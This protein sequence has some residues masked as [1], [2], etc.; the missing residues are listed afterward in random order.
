M[1]Q[2]IL[3]L[4][5]F[6]FCSILFA[7]SELELKEISSK[8]DQNKNAQLEK[9]LTLDFETNQEQ[10]DLYLKNNPFLAKSLNLEESSRW[11]ERINENGHPVFIITTNTQGAE[12]IGANQLYS[13]GSLGLDIDG[14]G[15][16]AGI[17][18]GGYVLQNHQE[19]NRRVRYGEADKSVSGHGTHVG[20]TMI[21][22]GDGRADARGMAPGGRLKSFRFD[23]DVNEMLEQAQDGLL[24]SNH[25]YGREVTVDTE[26]EVFGQYD[27]SARDFD[28]ITDANPYY[29]PV[30]SAGNDRGKDYNSGK[31]EY[32][33]LTDRTTSKNA[34]TVGA[35]TG[36]TDNDDPSNITMSN[37][38][39]WGP[40]DDG[41]IKPDLV[42]KGVS[43]LSTSDQSNTSYSVLQGTSMSS[44][45]VA[46]GLMLLHQLYNE[47]FESF[48][49]SA[50][51]K[52]LVLFTAKE[53]GNTPGPDYRFGWGLLDVEAAAE[54]L[55]NV[56]NLN[57]GVIEEKELADQESLTETF[58]A[59]DT[60]R[61]SFALSWTDLPG[62]VKSEYTI[63]DTTPVLINDLDL[64][65]VDDEGNEFFPYKL[66]VERFR[67][68][69]TTGVNNVDNIEI[70]HI[71]APAGNY[72]VEI[73]H[74]GVLDNPQNYSLLVNGATKA[75]ASTSSE[76]IAGLSIFPNP[77]NDFVN[78]T[79]NATSVSNNVTIQLY[80]TLGQMVKNESFNNNGRFNQRVNISDL[81][82]GV[83]F[84]AVSDGNLKSTRKLIVK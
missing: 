14:S 27:F 41:R 71:N 51:I 34:L 77:A 25:S 6:L 36:S 2:K 76:E 32:D 53:A 8:S 68:R 63:D 16:T 55:L 24:I 12:M 3:T 54:M 65:V 5:V 73:T 22:S 33:L 42:A 60:E 83:Y 26:L 46:G 48:M 70:I 37:F 50:T 82:S 69:A 81:R 56:S 58:T 61:I 35:V 75:T 23:N 1:F 59:V 10:V 29:L 78:I 44:P 4:T 17:W 31:A 64:K 39:S 72:R 19:F 47:L 28:A 40:T 15:I 52:G 7:Q 66:D 79:F 45:M 30:V 18:D 21:A 9:R 43:V 49:R 11:L 62:E 13:G 57:L 20:G 67:S 38:S 80:N 84:V 74:K